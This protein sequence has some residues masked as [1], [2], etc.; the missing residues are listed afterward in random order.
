MEAMWRHDAQQIGKS[1]VDGEHTG[2]KMPKA[3]PFRVGKRDWCAAVAVEDIYTLIS[4]AGHLSRSFYR[5][6]GPD[7]AL[8]QMCQSTQLQTEKE[9]EKVESPR[10]NDD[11]PAQ[12][13][14]QAE[15]SEKTVSEEPPTPQIVVFV[16]EFDA[17]QQRLVNRGAYQMNSA[18]TIVTSL[19]GQLKLGEDETWD[20][21]H[22]HTIQIKSK[23]LIKR[24]ST[25]SDLAYGDD[26]WDGVLIIA[27][28]RPTTPEYAKST[29]N[30]TFSAKL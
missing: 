26:P 7:S 8:R 15:D 5:T 16:K 12:E 27:Q 30:S 19:R 2:E 25:F 1:S 18:A 9:P 21:Y 29:L 20:F 4:G 28:R 10:P 3:T 22:E 14:K 23:H 17:L 6:E 24:S 11:R 13:P